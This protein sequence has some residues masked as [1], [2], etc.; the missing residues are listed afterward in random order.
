MH[1]PEGL[2]GPWRRTDRNEAGT[3]ASNVLRVFDRN[4]RFAMIQLDASLVYVYSH[5]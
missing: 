4:R 2:Y 5:L 3:K 1:M